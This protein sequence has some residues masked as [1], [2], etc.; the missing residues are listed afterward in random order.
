MPWRRRGSAAL[1]IK[2]GIKSGAWPCAC[3]KL[4]GERG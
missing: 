3:R 1:Y 2:K 4:M